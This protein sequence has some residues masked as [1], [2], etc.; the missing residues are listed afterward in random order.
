MK[1]NTFLLNIK[2]LYYMNFRVIK[3]RN[4]KFPVGTLVLSHSGWRSHYISNGNNLEPISFDLNG[5]SPSFTLGTLGMP[6]ATAY[7]GFHKLLEPKSGEIL[8]VNGAAGAVGSI[9]GQL[10]KIHGVKVI[11]FVGSDDKVNWCKNDLGF[12]HVFNYKKVK[13]SEAM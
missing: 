8:V 7:F 5:T 12:D 10:A 11:A 1:N 4:G 2:V 6:G 13:F 3:S 9:V